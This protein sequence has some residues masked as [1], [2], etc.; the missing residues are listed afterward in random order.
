LIA[1][2]GGG[3]G[4][5]SVGV[6]GPAWADL[7]KGLAAGSF[8][9][10]LWDTVEAVVFHELLGKA[11]SAFQA[12]PL[13]EKMQSFLFLQ[14]AAVTEDDFAL[15]RVLGRGGFGMVNGC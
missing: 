12:S 14:E 11:A 7:E 6:G 1:E 4:S 10:E 3:K 9:D 15:F 8:T 13:F 2:S 5:N